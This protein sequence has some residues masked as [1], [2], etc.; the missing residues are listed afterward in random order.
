ME[1][2]AS[3]SQEEGWGRVAQG[4][5]AVLVDSGCPWLYF[6]NPSQIQSERM[7]CEAS[8]SSLVG[9]CIQ[10]ILNPFLAYLFLVDIPSSL[11]IVFQKVLFAHG[12]WLDSELTKESSC[13]CHKHWGNCRSPISWSLG[14]P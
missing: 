8:L 10:F 9:F 2:V 7:F 12:K 6:E 5:A 1:D 11:R 13:L 3:G 4:R 14:G